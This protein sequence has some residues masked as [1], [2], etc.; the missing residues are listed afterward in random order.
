MWYGSTHCEEISKLHL[1]YNGCRSMEFLSHHSGG[2]TDHSL[3]VSQEH[4]FC[5]HVI[6]KVHF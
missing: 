2:E 6:L 3:D 5:L 1:G 4:K